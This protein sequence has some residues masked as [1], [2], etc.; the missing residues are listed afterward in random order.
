MIALT[1]TGIIA[2]NAHLY[3]AADGRPSL[4]FTVKVRQS[5]K[6]PDGTNTTEFTSIRCTK[7]GASKSDR[8]FL[9]GQKIWI[10]GGINVEHHAASPDDLLC[11]V[12]QFELL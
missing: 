10:R 4:A 6:L 8:F 2:E 12:W 7:T 11:P 1:F 3:E 9:K 5:R